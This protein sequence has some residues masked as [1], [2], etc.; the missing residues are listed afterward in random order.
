MPREMNLNLHN[1]MSM[2]LLAMI[3]PYK[4]FLIGIIYTLL[5]IGKLH[6]ATTLS[7]FKPHGIWILLYF[8]MDYNFWLFELPPFS[9]YPCQ[10]YPYLGNGRVV[11]GRSS[12]Y[13]YNGRLETYWATLSE[14]TDSSSK[15]ILQKGLTAY[16]QEEGKRCFLNLFL[17]LHGSN[18]KKLLAHTHYLVSWKV[19]IKL[20]DNF[21][22]L[23]RWSLTILF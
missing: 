4:Y 7:K 10:T 16:L 23:F 18:L 17:D 15:T 5:T 8:E 3:P 6:L 21:V 11:S 9:R 14:S 20:V 1:G 12:P 19:S 2:L 22:I 13:W